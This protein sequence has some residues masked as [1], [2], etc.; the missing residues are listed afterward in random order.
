MSFSQVLLVPAMSNE[1]TR[2]RRHRNFN[3][4]LSAIFGY[5]EM[6]FDEA[7]ASSARKRHAQN[8]LTAA[9]RGR[10]LVDQLLAY[11]RRERGRRA[12]TDV[13]R[14]VAETLEL[15]RSSLPASVTLQA[16]IPDD[17]SSLWAMQRRSTKWS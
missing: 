7:P 5:G 1:T 10:D 13:C 15:V 16:S 6:L 17:R 14:T 11:S 8:V 4:V 2:F 12:P 9:T 3:N